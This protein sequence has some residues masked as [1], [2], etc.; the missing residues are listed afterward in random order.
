MASGLCP[1]IEG[2]LVHTGAERRASE[3][4]LGAVGR[5]LKDLATRA[6]QHRKSWPRHEYVG[7]SMAMPT[8]ACSGSRISMPI[9]PPHGSHLAVARGR[10][11]AGGRR[12]WRAESRHRHVH[13]PV[14]RSPRDRR[15]AGG[16]IPA[17]G[18]GLSGKPG[19]D[20]GLIQGRA[21]RKIAP[22]G[23]PGRGFA[24]RAP[25]PDPVELQPSAHR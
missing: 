23:T 12:R 17:R 19:Y 14:G 22:S 6:K 18:G 5:D 11:K 13:D 2:R 1:L 10:E 21:P 16:R 15:R 4:A 25:Q 8:W 9:H 3:I 24:L 20:A 7:G